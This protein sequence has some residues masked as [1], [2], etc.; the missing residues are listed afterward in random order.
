MLDTHPQF[1][2]A[3]IT[4]GHAYFQKGNPEAA[5]EQYRRA[6]ALE[7]SVPSYDAFIARGLASTGE[8][9]KARHILAGLVE[10]A[11]ERYIRSEILAVGF[12]ALGEKDEAFKHLEHALEARSAGLIYLVVD[13]MYD[14]LRDDPRFRE[15]VEKVGLKT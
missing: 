4:M 6:Q 1:Y 3:Y 13:P 8:E 7:G 9:E 11:A 15:L 10:R 2:R 12:A 5:L 14:P